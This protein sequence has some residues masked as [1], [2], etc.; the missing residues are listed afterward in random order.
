MPGPLPQSS[1]TLN[2]D[3]VT[4]SDL[5][6]CPCTT[7]ISKSVVDESVP[8]GQG[9]GSLTYT[10]RDDDP[11]GVGGGGGAAGVTKLGFYKNC[12]PQPYSQMLDDKNPSC[13]LRSYVG[14]MLCCGHKV[15]LL[16]AEQAVPWQDQPLTY[17]LKF[18]IWYKRFDSAKHSAVVKW[19][20]SGL[21]SPT[22][23]ENGTLL[24]SHPLRFFV[25]SR[26]LMGC[27]DPAKKGGRCTPSVVSRLGSKPP[28][29]C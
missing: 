2:K 29:S 8:F 25:N 23:Y 19:G 6:E 3:G 14:G 16:D 20:W 13:D 28:H 10:P 7:R 26:T 11:V 5:M 18:R 15:S 22:E 4:Y 9:T 12:K 17:S 24:I 21:G 27:T 1:Q